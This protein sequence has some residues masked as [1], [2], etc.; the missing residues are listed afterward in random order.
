MSD[1]FQDAWNVVKNEYTDAEKIAAEK[2]FVN[3]ISE[4]VPERI[5]PCRDCGEKTLRQNNPL[6]ELSNLCHS[7]YLRRTSELGAVD[8]DEET[9]RPATTMLDLINAKMSEEGQAGDQQRRDLQ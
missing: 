3:Q 1:A 8:A 7:C 2:W 5:V 4:F 9:G 6:F